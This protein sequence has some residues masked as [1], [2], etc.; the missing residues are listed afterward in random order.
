M[1]KRIKAL[2][3]IGILVLTNQLFAA[4]TNPVVSNVAFSITGTT[5]TVT[6]DVA[7]TEEDAFTVYMEVSDDNG[8]TWDYDYG[9]ASGHIGASVAEGTGKTITWTYSGAYNANFKIKILADDLVGDQV[10]YQRHIFDIIEYG[11]QSYK[12]ITIGSQTWFAENLN[13][14]TKINSTAVGFQQTNNSIIEKY[15][16]YNV[17]EYCN[18]YGGLYEWTEAMQNVTTPGTQGICPSG[19]HI[20]TLAEMQ[21]LQTYVGN[22]A[23]KFVALGQPYQPSQAFTATNETGF[24]ALFAGTRNGFTRYFEATLQAAYF[25]SSTENG[26]SYAYY[27]GLFYNDSNVNLYDYNKH[28]GFSVRCLKN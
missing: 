16:Y 4:N 18:T 23:A 26:S 24:S 17:E 12:T 9:T 8:V 1:K 5:V 11:G 22:Q 20:P 2:L 25:W 3:I 19:W 27:L 6:Y 10:Y 21:T 14:G 13:I 28:M 7:D 15:C